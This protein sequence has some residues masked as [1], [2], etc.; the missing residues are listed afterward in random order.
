MFSGRPKQGGVASS[1]LLCLLVA[2]LDHPDLTAN[3]N[4][5]RKAEPPQAKNLSQSSW[6]K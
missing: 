6:G 5:G 3:Q 1:V 4:A 2:M